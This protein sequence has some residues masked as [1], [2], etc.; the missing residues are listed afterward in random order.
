[1]PNAPER[2]ERPELRAP[3]GPMPLG[4]RLQ[5]VGLL[6]AIPFVLLVGPTLG[7]VLG[8][9]CDRRWLSSPWGVGAGLVLGLL[10]SGRV[11]I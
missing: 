10:A 2:Q 5:Q 6:T 11:T 8:A 3:D 7:Y 1:M 4:E 9:A